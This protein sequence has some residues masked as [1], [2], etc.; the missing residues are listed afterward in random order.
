MRALRRAEFKVEYSLGY[1]PKPKIIFSLP[2]PLGVESMAE[3]SDVLLDQRIGGQEFK[4]RVNLRLKPQIQVIKAKKIAAE[5]VNLMNDIAVSLYSFRLESRSADKRLLERFY[6]DIKGDLKTE[7]DFSR[8]IFDL[9]ITQDKAGFHIFFL[10]L[11]GYAKIFIKENNEFF[12]FNNFYKYFMDWLKDYKID[13][14]GVKK[15]ELFVLRKNILK[16]PMEV[17]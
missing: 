1:N 17:V 8:S 5:T 2:T 13:V 14:K 11:F 15:E 3:Y 9:E 12:K 6:T 4:K 7:S 16:T 10:K